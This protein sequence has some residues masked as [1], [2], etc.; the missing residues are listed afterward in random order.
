[1]PHELHDRFSGFVSRRKQFLLLK[2]DALR[3]AAGLQRGKQNRI[4]G[5]VSAVGSKPAG[6]GRFKTSHCFVGLNG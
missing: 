6:N 5:G 2:L 3:I 4:L 1:L